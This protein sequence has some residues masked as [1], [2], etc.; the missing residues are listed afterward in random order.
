MSKLTIDITGVFFAANPEQLMDIYSPPPHN[1]CDVA[2]GWFDMRNTSGN[3]LPIGML[4][5]LHFSFSI[6][7]KE[8]LRG[9]RINPPF[10]KLS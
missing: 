10:Q 8:C 4:K 9:Q 5:E 3:I 1:Y 6:T 2:Q 7:F